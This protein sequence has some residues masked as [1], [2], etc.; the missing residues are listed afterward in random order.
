MRTLIFPCVIAAS[1]CLPGIEAA[2]AASRILQT[3]AAN[4]VVVQAKAVQRIKGPKAATNGVLAAL[5]PPPADPTYLEQLVAGAKA[6]LAD[7]PS[8]DPKRA[9]QRLLQAALAGNTDAM[10][11]L[12]DAYHRGDGV[13]ADDA[14]AE[15]TLLDAL[16]AGRTREASFA[17]GEL[18]TDAASPAFNL[19]KATVAYQTV[20]RFG[21]GL[22]MVRLANL[23]IARGKEA[24][25]FDRAR[26][27][28]EQA[29]KLGEIAAGASALGDLYFAPG[30]GRDGRKAAGLYE[31]AAKAGNSD[32]A[33]KLAAMMLAGTD[34]STDYPAGEA[35]IASVTAQGG[36][37]GAGAEWETIGDRYTAPGSMSPA[38]AKAAYEQAVVAKRPTAMVKLARLLMADQTPDLPRAKTLLDAAI[39]AGDAA[40][41]SLALGDLLS[42]AGVLQ[43]YKAA[44]G[45]YDAAGRAGS[46]AAMLK[47]AGL[48]ADGLGVPQ[49]ESNAVGM[50]ARA[51]QAGSAGPGGEFLGDVYIRFADPHELPK[52]IDAYGQAADAGNAGAMIK[53]ARLLISDD[54]DVDPER[55]RAM[56]LAALA[57]GRAKDA[58]AV[59]GDVYRLP[60]AAFKDMQAAADAYGKAAA[61]GDAPSMVKLGE[62]LVDGKSLPPNSPR[63]I[64]LFDEAAAAGNVSAAAERLGD[65]YLKYPD[66][67][68]DVTKALSEYET[69]AAAGNGSAH[70]KV[71]RLIS[72]DFK[73]PAKRTAMVTHYREAAKLLGADAAAVAIVNLN[74][75]AAVA[76]TQELLAGSGYGR[77]TADGVFK[78]STSSAINAY[79]AARAVSPCEAAFVTI[80]LLRSL[81]TPKA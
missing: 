70:L 42:M 54:V 78:P 8:R 57:A 35:L 10:L 61:L 69:A 66:P 22:A 7:G 36:G 27:L 23:V 55:A 30:P 64:I 37:K 71:A 50:A 76:V 77:G 44:S 73:K 47:L 13:E 46:A 72:P 41:G 81:L 28:L 39:A 79:C 62:M 32:A 29:I 74:A 38:K 63:A 43:D 24:N 26:M 31:Q 59:I 34:I 58:W 52:A 11:M 21:D 12:A 6:L 4:A 15:A 20:A 45:A 9:V 75:G 65:V 19:D 53:L 51:I 1:L 2:Q 68:G 16:V 60:E 80:D 48:Y 17:L 14:K 25:P 33:I 67:K 49:S 40:D 56:A 18:Y 3:A 5:P